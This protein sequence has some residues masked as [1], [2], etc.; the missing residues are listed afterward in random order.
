MDMKLVWSY[1]K[2][3]LE[4]MK[5]ETRSEMRKKSNTAYQRIIKRKWYELFDHM[6]VLGSKYKRLV[7]SFE[8]PNN[9]VYVG[10]THDFEERYKNHFS[11]KQ[12]QV[13]KE[14]MVSNLRPSV[15]LLSEYV[16]VNE[17]IKL[18]KYFVEKYK[19]DGFRILNVAKTG[20]LGGVNKKLTIEICHNVALKYCTVSDFMKSDNSVYVTCRKNGWLEFVTSHMSK[21]RQKNNF[22]TFEKLQNEALKFRTKREFRNGSTAYAV[23]HKKRLINDICKHMVK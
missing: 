15:K 16:D 9:S 7:Y 13:Y 14:Y 19:T 2:C 1:D 3:S 22:W 5:F 21:K 11:D 20:G 10:I 12:S 18:E 8:F 4:A 17:A 6:K 23:A